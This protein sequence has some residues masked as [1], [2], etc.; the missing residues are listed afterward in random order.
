MATK[1]STANS[2]TLHTYKQTM[3]QVRDAK[4]TTQGIDLTTVLELAVLVVRQHAS[5][6]YV[7]MG[8]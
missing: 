1:Q 2:M 3:Q 8:I 5:A 4:H 6:I 7:C